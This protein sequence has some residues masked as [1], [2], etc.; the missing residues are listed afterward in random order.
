MNRNVKDIYW[1][2]GFLDGEG[3]FG[4]SRSIKSNSISP[5]IRVSSTDEYIIHKAST[6]LRGIAWY[7]N[8]LPRIGEKVKYTA[9]INGPVAIGWMMTIL[10]L[11]CKRRQEKIKEVIVEW[12]SYQARRKVVIPDYNI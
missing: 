1:L 2:A 6:L 10:P 12:K 11:M 8:R 4:V 7:T 5:E 3:W 9:V